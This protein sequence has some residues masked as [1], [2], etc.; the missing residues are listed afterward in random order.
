LHW[1]AD[2]LSA[3]GR[4]IQ[5]TEEGPSAKHSI[6]NRFRDSSVELNVERFGPNSPFSFESIPTTRPL[7]RVLDPDQNLSA[8]ISLLRDLENP[9][10]LEAELIHRFAPVNF[11]VPLPE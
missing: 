5:A 1:T 3:A 4:R 11:S 2:I 8:D 10:N 7:Y 9:V 6:N